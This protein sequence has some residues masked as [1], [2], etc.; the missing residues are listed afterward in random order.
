MKEYLLTKISDTRIVEGYIN[1]VVEYFYNEISELSSYI[2][3]LRKIIKKIKLKKNISFSLTSG[4]FGTYGKLIYDSLYHNRIKVFSA[5]HGIGYSFSKDTLYTKYEN[6]SLT[7]D[8][9]FCYNN[10]AKA[11]REIN[12]NSNLK[13]IPIGAPSI[14]KKFF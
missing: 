3:S 13:M 8:Y 14:T 9:L 7:S 5:E 12:K 2:D 11:T 4:L 10:S 1:I 6:E